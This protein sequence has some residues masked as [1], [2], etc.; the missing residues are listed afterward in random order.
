[1][2]EADARDILHGSEFQGL[3]AQRVFLR[4]SQLD[5]GLAIGRRAPDDVVNAVSTEAAAIGEPD[6]AGARAQVNAISGLPTRELAACRALPSRQPGAPADVLTIDDLSSQPVKNQAAAPLVD[7]DI[8]IVDGQH[9]AAAQLGVA[10]CGQRIDQARENIHVAARRA[11]IAAHNRGRHLGVGRRIAVFS[12]IGQLHLRA[13]VRQLLIVETQQTAVKSGVAAHDIDGHRQARRRALQGDGARHGNRVKRRS[14]RRIDAHGLP[15]KTRALARRDRAVG[16]PRFGRAAHH[17][18][19]DGPGQG[20]LLGQCASR[21]DRYHERRGVSRH[22]HLALHID[23]AV[24]D[25]ST[26]A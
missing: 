8:T 10:A 25:Q 4:S 16:D 18:H 23:I 3:A 14:I 5:D 17:I 7:P 15:V 11:H 2:S 20:E 9:I 6:I 22:V 13:R 1:M 19:I 24:L 12:H 26:G 21:A